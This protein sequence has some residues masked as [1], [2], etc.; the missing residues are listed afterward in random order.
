MYNNQAEPVP[1][2][3]QSLKVGILADV[4]ARMPGFDPVL[5]HRALANHTHRDGYLLALIHIRG[6]R[7]YGLDGQPVGIVTPEEPAE[8]TQLLAACTQRRHTKAER[9][10]EHLALEA[11]RWQ[12]REVEQRHREAKAARK[13]EYE[14]QEQEITACKA[15]LLAPGYHASGIFRVYRNY[16]LQKQ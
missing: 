11:K 5:L 7:C 8:V 6:G 2:D 1:D 15:A 13:A 12:Q 3:I 16:R 9:V 14:R 10:R 4:I